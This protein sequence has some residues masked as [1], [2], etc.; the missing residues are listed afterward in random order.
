[1][2]QYRRNYVPGGTYFFTLVAHRRRPTF[3]AESARVL[4]RE[5]TKRVQGKRPFEIVAF[6]LLPEH[7]HVVW[8]LP[9]G[10][11]NYSTRW[12]LIKDNFTR[13]FLANGG[14]EG[15]RT[16]SRTRRR[17]RAVWQRRFWEHTCEDEEDLKNC[18]DY[19][20][21]NPVKHGLVKRVWDYPWSTFHA[22]VT[23]GEY[24]LEWGKQDPC[25]GYESPEWL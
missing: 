7:L 15:E 20:H 5:E 21:Y 24:D 17:E 23:R 13:R 1:M 10:D 22:F 25:P 9:E 19:I 4:L 2:P 6:V 16:E 8:I 11:S 18:V 14:T 12:S 3:A